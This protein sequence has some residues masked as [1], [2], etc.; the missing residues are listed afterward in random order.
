MWSFLFDLVSFLILSV[1]MY[2]ICNISILWKLLMFSFLNFFIDVFFILYYMFKFGEQFMYTWE[3]VFFLIRVQ[4][5]ISRRFT[6]LILLC[7]FIMSFNFV[8]LTC[9]TKNGIFKFPIIG[10]FLFLLISPIN[11]VLYRWFAVLS[12][13]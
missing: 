3:D 12:V 4:C 1:I 6:F 10:M 9:F 8:H 5:N 2:I 7:S 13:A 11:F